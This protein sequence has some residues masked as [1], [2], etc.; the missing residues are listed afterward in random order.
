MATYR[1][2]GQGQRLKGEGETNANQGDPTP[3]HITWIGAEQPDETVQI[4]V[5]D[6]VEYRIPIFEAD[7]GLPATTAPGS[8]AD[9]ATELLE[10]DGGFVVHTMEPHGS[11]FAAMVEQ[12]CA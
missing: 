2:S 3:L 5:F 11:G 6:S 10:I 1:S 12:R 8:V 4:V 7:T 9:R